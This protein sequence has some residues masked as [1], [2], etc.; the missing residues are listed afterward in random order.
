M[1]ISNI[2]NKIKMRLARWRLERRAQRQ[3]ER[4]KLEW[5]SRPT[6]ER[7]AIGTCEWVRLKWNGNEEEFLVN[8]LNVADLAVSGR[9]PNVIVY[10]MQ[11]AKQESAS[12]ED[13][14][15]DPVD[16]NKVKEEEQA[17]YEEVARQSMVS[18]SFQE[19]YDSILKMRRERNIQIDVKTIKDVMPYDF[20]Q[21][22]F[23][24]HLERWVAMIK[25]NLNASTSTALAESQ[26]ISNKNP[27]HTFHN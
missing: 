2:I 14:L 13:E 17:L 19:V 27:L 11:L 7:L 1:F 5:Y 18:P 24:Y 20:L 3:I 12:D 25:K 10:F 8:N 23:K 22:L 9:Y 16:M 21:D 6:S 26:N 15:I 4:Q